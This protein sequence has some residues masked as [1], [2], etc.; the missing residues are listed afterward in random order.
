[1]IILA[2]LRYALVSKETYCHGNETYYRTKR[3][4]II[5]AHLSASRMLCGS[6]VTPP[7]PPTPP[8]PQGVAAGAMCAWLGLG[9]P[10]FGVAREGGSVLGGGAPLGGVGW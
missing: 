2:Y 3:R 1:M 7:T 9:A 8:P 10:E 4:L 5:L 6:A